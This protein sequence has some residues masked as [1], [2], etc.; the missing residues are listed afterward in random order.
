MLVVMCSTLIYNIVLYSVFHGPGYFTLPG[1]C[2]SAAGSLAA[3]LPPKEGEED[4][5]KP[6]TR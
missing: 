4:L 6:S 1:P 3:E 5:A 2:V